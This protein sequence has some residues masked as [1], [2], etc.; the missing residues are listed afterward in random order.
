[1]RFFRWMPTAVALWVVAAGFALLAAANIWLAVLAARGSP[2]VHQI[3]DSQNLT[4][5]L[6]R[7]AATNALTAGLCIS[8]WR[9]MSRRSKTGLLTGGYIV[10][11][12]FFITSSRWMLSEIQSPRSGGWIEPLLVWPFLIYPIVYA[13]AERQKREGE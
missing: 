4:G 1:V 12:A 9:L 2:S 8:G 13:F 11:V 5:D 6:L 7:G 3:T 10:V